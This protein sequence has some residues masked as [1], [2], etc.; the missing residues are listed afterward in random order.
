MEEKLDI[1]ITKLDKLI[2][3]MD[4]FVASTNVRLTVL[5]KTKQNNDLS[6]EPELTRGFVSFLWIMLHK[7]V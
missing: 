3:S 7:T 5:E 2:T 4:R 6:L 1:I